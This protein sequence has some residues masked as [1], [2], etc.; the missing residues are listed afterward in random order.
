MRPSG[1]SFGCRSGFGVRDLHGG[2]WDWT[3]SPW[4]RGKSGNQ[5]AVRG[6]NASHGDVVGRCANAEPRDPASKSGDIGFRCCAGPRNSAEVTLVVDDGPK[7]TALQRV[8]MELAND[9]AELLPEDVKTELL[10]RGILHWTRSWTWRPVANEVLSVLAGCAGELQ[11]RRCGVAV[12]RRPEGRLSVLG[13]APSGHYLPVARLHGNPRDL[14]V[15][16]GDAQSHYRRLVGYRWGRV[17][18]GKLERN[19][20]L[21]GKK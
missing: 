5:A 2:A 9:V 12:V 8:D 3:D 20:K 16:G 15:Y 17:R 21:S 7:L 6:G 14:W 19:I 1:L 11:R 4:G 13:W 10:G 18:L